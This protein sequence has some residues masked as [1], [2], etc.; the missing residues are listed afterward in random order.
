MKY[1]INGGCGF[2]GSNMAAHYIEAG[3]EVIVFDNLY[4]FGTEKNLEE[5]INE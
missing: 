5:K 4:R 3:D 2:L 1:L